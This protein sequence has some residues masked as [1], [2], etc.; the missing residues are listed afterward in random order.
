MLLDG[1]RKHEIKRFFR[2]QYGVGGRQ[3]ETYLLLARKRIAE[4]NTED[5]DQ[6]R[7]EF[8][9]RYMEIYRTS[10]NDGTKLAALRAAG[11]LFGVDA[12]QKVAQTTTDGKDTRRAA[13]EGLSV[14]QLRT[15]RDVRKHMEKIASGDGESAN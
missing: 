5:L 15:L 14:E 13:V 11:S 7:A 9:A 1:R 4:V 2:T 6:M 8:Y 10:E 12:P 3:V